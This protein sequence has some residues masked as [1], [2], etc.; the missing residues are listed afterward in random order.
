[1]LSLLAV[2]EGLLARR[3]LMPEEFSPDV[4]YAALDA[5]AAIGK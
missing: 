2:T 1:M 4:V 3:H 5:L